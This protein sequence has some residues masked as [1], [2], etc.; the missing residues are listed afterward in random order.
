MDYLHFSMS[1]LYKVSG[2]DGEVPQDLKYRKPSAHKKA[3]CVYCG[4]VYTGRATMKLL[5]WQL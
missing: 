4:D 3:S 1:S 2:G 5:L